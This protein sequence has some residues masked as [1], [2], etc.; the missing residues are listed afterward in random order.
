VDAEANPK[1]N[2]GINKWRQYFAVPCTVLWEVGIA[3]LEG[4]RKYGRHNYR[5]SR[6]VASVYVDAAKGHIDQ[7]VEGE[8]IDPD[9]GLCHITKAIATL[10]VLKDAMINNMCVDDRPPKVANLTEFRDDLQKRLNEIMARHPGAAKP[11]TEI[12][13][14]KNNAGDNDS[15]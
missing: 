2:I 15:M 4:A 13:N 12:D 11:F 6:I 1:H 8:D 5:V 3:M 9:S 14:G 7:W 10:F